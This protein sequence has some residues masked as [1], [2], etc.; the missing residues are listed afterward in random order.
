MRVALWQFDASGDKAANLAKVLAGVAAAAEAGAGLVVF[1][2]YAM[3]WERVVGPEVGRQAEP[4]DGPFVAAVRAAA[5]ERRIAVVLNVFESNPA[6]PRPWNTV[7]ALD[8][9]GETAGVYRKAHLYD[10]F[11]YRESDAFSAGPVAAATVVTLAGL[12]VGLQVCY[13]LRFPEGARSAVDAGAELILYPAAWVPGPR[14]EQHWRTLLAARAIENTA[15]VAGV[16]MTFPAGTAGTQLVD[17]SGA[18]LGEV[19][20]GEAMLL[21]EVD[22]A[23]L[24]GVRTK[25]PSLANRRFAVAPR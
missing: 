5:A 3:F 15:Y 10:A 9:S 7:I 11:G 13:D 6:D 19:P 1:P 4:L 12:R 25:N 21:V 18:V 23:A 24:A 8:E 22:G 2:E 16:G 14:K 17:P 20:G